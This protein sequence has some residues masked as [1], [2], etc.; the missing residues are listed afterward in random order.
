MQ[1]FSVV[2]A[3]FGFKILSLEVIKHRKFESRRL[4]IFLRFISQRR[5]R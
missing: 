2:T 5:Q 4:R 3:S 1:K